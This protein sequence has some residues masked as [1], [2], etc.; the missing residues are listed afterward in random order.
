[1]ISKTVSFCDTT[2]KD[3]YSGPFLDLFHIPLA[4]PTVFKGAA[5]RELAQWFALFPSYPRRHR[6]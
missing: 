5:A 6:L 4:D 3:P 1:M 2:F